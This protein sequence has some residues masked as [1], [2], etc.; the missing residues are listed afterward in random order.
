M[1]S[2]DPEIEKRNSTMAKNYNNNH[3]FFNKFAVRI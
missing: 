3:G 2:D 1:I